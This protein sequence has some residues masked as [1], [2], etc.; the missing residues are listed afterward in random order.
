MIDHRLQ[1]EEN[2]KVCFTEWGPNEVY[3]AIKL[4]IL[5][6]VLP[7]RIVLYPIYKLQIDDVVPKHGSYE[8]YDIDGGNKKE[9]KKEE[10]R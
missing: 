6:T 5:L 9:E 10:E 4:R 3:S 1:C 8:L 2:R 7:Q